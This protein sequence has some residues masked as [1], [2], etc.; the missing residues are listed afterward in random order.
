MLIFYGSIVDLQRWLISAVQESDLRVCV[1]DIL[2]FMFFPIMVYLR[3]LNIQFS[4]L[5]GRSLLFVY[6]ILNN[7]LYGI[8]CIY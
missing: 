4:M 6:P 1:C 5:Y 7:L 3:T 8:I 2:F